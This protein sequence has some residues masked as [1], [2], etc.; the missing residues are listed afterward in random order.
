M[1]FLRDHFDFLVTFSAFDSVIDEIVVDG[2]PEDV[3][4][5]PLDV[6]GVVGRACYV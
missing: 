3:R 4:P 2:A 6:D 1:I 5:G